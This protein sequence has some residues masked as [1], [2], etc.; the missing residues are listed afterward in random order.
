MKSILETENNREKC[1]KFT[2]PNIVE[3]MLDMAE[4]NVNLIGKG[5]LKIHLVLGI[6]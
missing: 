5:F 6:Y 3:N 1:Q 4:Y 2:P